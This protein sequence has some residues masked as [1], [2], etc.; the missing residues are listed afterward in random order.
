MRRF[1]DKSMIITGAARG[2][3]AATARRAAAE[4]AKVVVAD[5]LGDAAEALAGEIVRAG[6][7][8]GGLH[9]ECHRAAP[10]GGDGR[11]RRPPVRPDH[12]AVNNASIAP[13]RLVGCAELDDAGWRSVMATNAGGVFLCCR[14]GFRQFLR[15]GDGGVIVNIASVAGLTAL[16]N[17]PSYTASKHAVV[18][19]TRSIA[20]D[21]A[22]QGIRCNAICPAGHGDAVGCRGGCRPEPA[23][24]PGC[25]PGPQ[26]GGTLAAEGL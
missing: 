25:Q 9:D 12:I 5:I 16:S 21:Y 26:A 8:G 4:G 17:C 15:Q 22:G 10:G 18:G 7:H 1:D 11:S 6:R 2:I 13:P 20:R 19:L 23:S 14:A 3:G 24:C